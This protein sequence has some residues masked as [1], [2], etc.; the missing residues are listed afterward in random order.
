VSAER[1]GSHNR[2]MELG[3]NDPLALSFVLN[4]DPRQSIGARLQGPQKLEAQT[5]SRGCF[6]VVRTDLA[7][8]VPQV[9]AVIPGLGDQSEPPGRR[10]V[11]PQS[12]AAIAPRGMG[13]NV[14]DR[15]RPPLWSACGGQSKPTIP[16]TAHGP[17]PIRIR[18]RNRR[19]ARVRFDGRQRPGGGRRGLRATHPPGLHEA[20]VGVEAQ[21]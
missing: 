17:T 19:L 21:T 13:R 11:V 6:L 4:P 15:V 5:R 16:M 2:G 7:R 20:S 3:H 14:P 1:P 10:L 8:P 18:R 9:P 12:A